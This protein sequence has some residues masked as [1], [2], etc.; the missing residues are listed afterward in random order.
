MPN[1]LG[2]MMVPLV[3]P[4]DDAGELARD[5]FERQV[6]Y[7]LDAGVS[8]VLVAGS[9]GEAALLDDDERARLVS[10]AREL[11][12][13]DRW[14]LAGIGAESTRATIRRAQDAEEAGADAV[15]VV[16]PH[17]YQ[18]R[19]TDAALEAHFR[20][21]ADA[22][23]LPVLLY[24]V[25]AY[26]HL[27]LSPSLVA[28]L[29][30]HANVVGMKDSAGNLPVLAEYLTAQSSTF[31]VLTGSGQTTREAL[32]AGASGAIVA[33]GVFAAPLVVALEDAVRHGDSAAAEA[34]QARLTP[35]ARTI[36]AEMGPPGLKGAMDAVGLDAG[37]PRA[38]LRPLDDAER[39]RVAALLAECGVPVASAAAALA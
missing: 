17:Y 1:T 28:S 27:V 6:R 33:V 12:P 37:A 20:A 2:G 8:G 24:N 18:R 10:W 25:P 23:P 29:A 7:Y 13:A 19:M 35:L 4:F 9:S 16:A 30:T 21:V 31:R 36:V 39:A 22:S 3:T 26:A 14:L 32:V 11:V 38:P 5:R 15:L 34:I